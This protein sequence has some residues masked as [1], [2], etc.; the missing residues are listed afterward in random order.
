M[1]DLSGCPVAPEQGDEPFRS[2]HRAAFRIDAGVLG[3]A[4]GK[5]G[6]AFG[7]HH[8]VHKRDGSAADFAEARADVDQVVVAGGPPVAARCLA[9]GQEDAPAFDFGI[10]HAERPPDVFA[11]AAFKKVQVFRVVN[12]AHRICFPIGN[13][14]RKPDIGSGKFV[15]I[16]ED[17]LELR[18]GGRS[19][20]PGL[21]GRSPAG[22][23]AVLAFAVLGLS[24][25]GAG[26]AER[27]SSLETAEAAQAPSAAFYTVETPSAATVE[28]AALD[29]AGQKLR[30]WNEL[31]PAVAASRA[32]VATRD[33][34]E[35]A[36]AR[37][38]LTVTWAEVD[39]SLARLQ[40]L[41]PRLDAEPELLARSF[42]W[43]GLSD[44]AEFSGYYE[45]VVKASRKRVPGYAYPL[46]RLPPDLKRLD[47]GEFHPELIGQ[48]VV[49][50]LARGS[51]VPY[52]SRADIDEKGALV[53][54]GLELAWL[55]DPLDR[56]FLH[57]QGSGRLH[58]TDGSEQPVAYAGT[59]G[60]S[61]VSIGRHLADLGLIPP[62]EVTMH[63]IRDWL[64]AHP[65]EAQ[66]TLRLNERYVFFRESDAPEPA[67]SMGRA[68][69]PLVSLAVD[70]SVFPLGAPLVFAVDL[71]VPDGGGKAAT[72]PVRGIGLAQ[73]AGGAIV[74]RRV[75][76]FCGSGDEAAFAAGRL[77]GPGQVW[78]LLL[79]E[80]AGADKGAS[81]SVQR[82]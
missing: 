53:G 69:T 34:G 63:A 75:D 71:P 5:Q 33:A 78:M 15:R 66:A 32:Y 58:F 55:A 52:Y 36:V 3:E 62:G 81:A 76:L 19:G 48:R 46:Y 64:L 4:F 20:L 29:P 57:V 59:N 42:R 41:L 17:H 74:G 27:R 49:Y 79:P 50:R 45:P 80:Q 72:R 43:V 37:G 44:G 12:I 56:Y 13:T 60:R 9:D 8:S 23:A 2:A 73:D 67:G 1:R 77:N 21:I 61:Y 40:E 26:C 22:R 25:L 16:H 6:L 51:V 65:D 28:A 30:S 7:V 10:A 24:V 14:V 35:V 39:A 31:A 38:D 47:L 18:V 68:L 82:R 11:P 70:R 54:R